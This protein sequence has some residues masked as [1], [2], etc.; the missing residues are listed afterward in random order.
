[1]FNVI[2]WLAIAFFICPHITLLIFIM[3]ILPEIIPVTILLILVNLEPTDFV[4]ALTCIDIFL[5]FI[6]IPIWNALLDY[7]LKD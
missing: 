4:V 1:M 3:F 2:L 5:I 7:W 6:I